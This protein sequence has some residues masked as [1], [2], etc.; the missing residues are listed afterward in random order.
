MK[1]AAL[2]A[3]LALAT[4]PVTVLLPAPA[5]AQARASC[6]VSGGVYECTAT[7]DSF[8]ECARAS[9]RIRAIQNSTVKED[10]PRTIGSETSERGNFQILVL[11][12]TEGDE[13][14]LVWQS[15][16]NIGHKE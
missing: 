9:G 16:A 13:Y 1:R 6:P 14:L 12:A 2:A 11:C 5:K 7:F 10:G 4:L 15:P 3:A 8:A